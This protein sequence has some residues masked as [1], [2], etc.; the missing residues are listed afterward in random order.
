MDSISG[1]ISNTAWYKSET[2]FGSDARSMKHKDTLVATAF[3]STH[4]EKIWQRLTNFRITTLP[5]AASKIRGF[6]IASLLCTGYSLLLLFPS[7]LLA[8]ASKDAIK[9]FIRSFRLSVP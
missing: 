6:L 2:S 3:T 9:F 7:S 1:Q 4:R 5:V 8:T